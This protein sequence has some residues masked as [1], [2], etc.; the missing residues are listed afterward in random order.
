MSIV[1]GGKFVESVDSL[2][3]KTPEPTQS[4]VNRES[5]SDVVNAVEKE[6]VK[7]LSASIVVGGKVIDS[8]DSLVYK[9]PEPTAPV[10]EKEVINQPTNIDNYVK[11]Y[12]RNFKRDEH[13]IIQ[14]GKAKAIGK[15]SKY[16]VDMLTT[17]E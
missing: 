6:P 4:P 5:I 17:E 14:N 11:S 2:V 10:V 7:K 9:N 3:V 15:Q 1:V 16:L 8:I 13:Y 12:P